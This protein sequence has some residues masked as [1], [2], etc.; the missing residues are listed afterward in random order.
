MDPSKMMLQIQKTADEFL[1]EGRLISNKNSRR[2]KVREG[3]SGSIKQRRFRAA[4][5]VDSLV[6]AIAWEWLVWKGTLP[7]GGRKDHF[8]WACLQLMLYPSENAISTLIDVD[9]KTFRKWSWDFLL[10]FADLESDVVS[11]CF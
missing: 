4:F 8:L 9:E 10:A 6:C 3:G 2:A 7:R 5:G 1:I 11:K